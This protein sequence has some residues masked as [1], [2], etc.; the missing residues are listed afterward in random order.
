[1]K[2]LFGKHKGLDTSDPEIPVTYLKWLEEQQF[3]RPELRTDLFE[4]IRR[5][6]G[7]RPGAGKA[8]RR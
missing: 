7:D 2:L 6:D 4:E 3:I 1:M 5:R 8:V